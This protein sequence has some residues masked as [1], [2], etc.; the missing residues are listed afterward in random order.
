MWADITVIDAD[1]LRAG[2]GGRPEALLVA[3]VLFTIVGGRVVYARMSPK[4]G[5]ARTR[6]PAHNRCGY[7]H[8]WISVYEMQPDGSW[9][10][11]RDVGEEIKS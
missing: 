8:R 4:F 2:S 11:I 7:P 1:P 6:L 5:L 9:L 10:I 3:R